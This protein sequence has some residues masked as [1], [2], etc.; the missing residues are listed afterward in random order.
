MDTA[1]QMNQNWKIGSPQSIN[2]RGPII[3]NKTAD[4]TVFASPT[5][6]INI[7]LRW[8]TKEKVLID[9]VEFPELEAHHL[10]RP[11]WTWHTKEGKEL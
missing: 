10:N 3:W 8:P 6:L 5:R 7:T 11:L 9:D 1:R 4:I 2:Q